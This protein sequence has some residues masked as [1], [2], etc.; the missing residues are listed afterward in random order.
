MLA[1]CAI[2]LEK[3]SSACRQRTSL[4][5]MFWIWILKYQLCFHRILYWPTLACKI[6]LVQLSFAR[7]KDQKDRLD[8][9]PLVAMVFCSHHISD[10]SRDLN[11]KHLHHIERPHPTHLW[12]RGG[13]QLLIGHRIMHAQNKYRCIVVRRSSLR[14]RSPSRVGVSTSTGHMR[15]F[16]WLKT[17]SLKTGMVLKLTTS[18]KL[19][20]FTWRAAKFKPWNASSSA[21]DVVLFLRKLT[22]KI[23]VFL[24]SVCSA[25]WSNVGVTR[26]LYLAIRL[27]FV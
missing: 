20:C 8:V 21:T 4:A 6:V 14:T 7:R 27:N 5:W 17:C 9:L 18:A 16:T 26:W 11:V 25:R 10:S 2:L 23:G 15:M 24:V 1:F 19:I 13:I 12:G 22:V 3:S